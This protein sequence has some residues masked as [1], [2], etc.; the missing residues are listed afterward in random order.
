MEMID[1]DNNNIT[2]KL[3][4]DFK[5]QDQMFNCFQDK[6]DDNVAYDATLSYRS[7]CRNSSVELFLMIM[8]LYS[9]I[10]Y[11][12]VSFGTDS[13]GAKLKSLLYNKLNR[14]IK[15]IKCFYSYFRYYV[16]H[17]AILPIQIT[18][19][20]FLPIVN[21]KSNNNNKSSAIKKINNINPILVYYS[22]WNC[23]YCI[24]HKRK[25]LKYGF[26]CKIRSKSNLLQKDSNI[27]VID[28]NKTCELL[29]IQACIID[30]LAQTNVFG[31][32][33]V[34][35]Q[36]QKTQK[37][38]ALSLTLENEMIFCKLIKLCTFIYIIIHF[39]KIVVI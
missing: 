23:I 14:S 17:F 37:E 2:K 1:K 10:W 20:R 32:Y 27:F 8:K 34:G 11:D 21:Y 31:N 16:N 39:V 5:I 26:D 12:F 33:F 29:L 7:G 28:S 25:D 35:Y 36:T 3:A 13:F 15:H 24:I 22:I 38:K 4:N 9:R 30:Q 18:E 6:T 19:S